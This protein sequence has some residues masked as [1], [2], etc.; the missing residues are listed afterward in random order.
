MIA[1]ISANNRPD[2]MTTPLEEL[3][4]AADKRRYTQ[5]KTKTSITKSTEFTEATETKFM[6]CL[7]FHSLCSLCPLW[8]IFLF[9]DSICVHLRLYL[10]LGGAWVTPPSKRVPR[11]N[12]KIR[13]SS[14]STISRST[15]CWPCSRI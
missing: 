14:S 12:P 11:W 5:T 4:L 7:I 13:S 10:S 9:L 3:Q 15:A 8:L 6:T 1:Q 2:D